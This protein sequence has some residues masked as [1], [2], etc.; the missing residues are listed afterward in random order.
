MNTL[1]P[2]LATEVVATLLLG[3]MAGFFFAFAVDVAP[4]M[5]QLDAAHY[6]ATQQAINRVVR[7]A[8]FG[9]VYFGSAVLT[10]LAAV[11]AWRSGGKRAAAGWLVVWLVYAVGVFW[12][13]RQVNVP[14][15]DALAQWNPAA[16]PVDWMAARDRWN[17]ANL[18]RAWV[19]GVCFSGALALLARRRA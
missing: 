4:A 1:R 9:S 13:T 8:A 2:A 6:I 18:V 19:A 10:A 12:L 11:L 15:N 14:I 17:S 3:L 5:A 7:N 16:A